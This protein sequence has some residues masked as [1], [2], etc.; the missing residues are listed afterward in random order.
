MAR[1]KG[2]LTGTK[3]QPGTLD[4]DAVRNLVG[5]VR[6]L[7][8]I[9]DEQK[10]LRSEYRRILND[11]HFCGYD[12]NAVLRLIWMLDVR[13]GAKQ[14]DPLD[15]RRKARLHLY[16]SPLPP[17]SQVTLSDIYL[18]KYDDFEFEMAIEGIENK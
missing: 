17:D 8:N 3:W 11:M 18:A 2:S 7:R 10:K 1:T 6:R 4:E 9:T 5:C 13:D 14:M 15:P 16:S 12:R